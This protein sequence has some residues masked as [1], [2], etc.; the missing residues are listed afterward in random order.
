MSINTNASIPSQTIRAKGHRKSISYKI[1]LGVMAVLIPSLIVLIVIACVVAARAIS[2]LNDRTLEIQTKYA[3]SI[4]DKFLGSKVSAVSMYEEDNMLAAFLGAVSSPEDIEAYENRHVV[5]NE[6]AGA[7]RRMTEEQVCEVWVAD[8]EADMYLLSSGDTVKA[9]LKENIWYDKV[10]NDEQAAVS[11]PYTDPATGEEIISVVTPV[12]AAQR[13]GRIA[14]FLGFDVYMSSLSDLLSGIKVGEQGYI[15]LISGS[16]DFIYS[17]DP[18]ARGKNVDELDICDEYKNNVHGDFNGQMDFAY[19]D[20][21][22]TAVFSN[23]EVTGWLVVATLPQAEVDATRNHLIFMMALVSV[24]ILSALI[25]VITAII[26]RMMYPLTEISRNMEEFSQGNLEVDIRVTGSDE[27]GRLADSV[28][29]A[30]QSLKDMIRNASHILTEIS[31]GNLNLSVEGNYIG[32][33]RSIRE[34]LEKI[35][36]SMNFTMGQIN[37]AAAQVS[38]GAEQVSAG[39]QALSQGASDQAGTVEELAISIND[40]SGQIASNAE[41]AAQANERA[42]R[43]SKEAADSSLRMKN[44]L[45]A[46]KNISASS[47]EIEKVV[48]SIEDIA[49]QTNIL[50]LNASVEAA[51]AGESGRGFAVVAGEIRT[52]ATKSAQ[53]AKS[54]AVLI[55]NSLGAVED[56]V[57]IADEAAVSLETV[58]EGVQTVVAAIDEISSASGE[59]ARAVEQVN[60]GIEQISGVVQVNSATAEESAAASQELS[61]QALML[62]ELIGKFRLKK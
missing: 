48:K 13:G 50:S 33:F 46:M 20:K 43:V 6:L 55:Q 31:Q 41:S 12:F 51:R 45:E 35:T 53:A 47:R 2:D 25:L 9:D 18:T 54:T 39:A 36:E 15:E 23:S 16:S 24:I 21:R 34:A 10:M 28:R 61:A 7:L 32:D 5:V 37:I 3:V 40:I 58:V 60:Q 14:G 59:Q 56:G 49:F 30:M 17:N 4:V 22:Y 11:E 19:K 57:K 38:C 1:S 52:L 26:R 27:I 42:A 29:N 8:T 62:E 44:L